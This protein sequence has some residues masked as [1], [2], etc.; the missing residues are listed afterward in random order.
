ME[1]SSTYCLPHKCMYSF[2]SKC[3]PFPLGNNYSLCLKSLWRFGVFLEGSLKDLLKVSMK[4]S[5]FLVKWTPLF[6]SCQPSKSYPG[7]FNHLSC[8][9]HLF[10]HCNSKQ[11]LILSWD[12]WDEW[13]KLASGTLLWLQKTSRQLAVL[14]EVRWD[15]AHSC[16][17]ILLK[18]YVFK[19]DM[20]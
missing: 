12:S 14:S 19:E 13:N 9:Y 17:L 5:F 8:I 11:W 20:T 15:E 7:D 6:C 4:K 16:P 18:C 1:F 3:S 2:E 10:Y